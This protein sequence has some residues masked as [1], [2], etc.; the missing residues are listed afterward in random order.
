[1][2]ELKDTIYAQFTPAQIKAANQFMDAMRIQIYKWKRPLVE[3]KKLYKQIDDEAI[4]A[5]IPAAASCKKGCSYCCHI[6]VDVSIMEVA[7]LA[8]YVRKQDKQLIDKQKGLSF[9]EFIELP[10]AD[11][12]CIFLENNVCRVYHDRPL[13]C[14]THFVASDPNLCN[15]QTGDH[16][17]V[18]LANG[19]ISLLRDSFHSVYKNDANIATQLLKL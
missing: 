19:I 1:M 3:L 14:R 11:K 5:G 13:A 8:P 18:V 2:R 16:E 7:L 12:K 6:N 4:D 15:S 10:Y 9:K 17:T